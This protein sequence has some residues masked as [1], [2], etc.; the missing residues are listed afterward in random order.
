[1]ARGADPVDVGAEPIF[2]IFSWWRITCPYRRMRIGG[3]V[4]EGMYVPW[5]AL[6]IF[7]VEDG[8]GVFMVV[9]GGTAEQSEL[10]GGRWWC[11]RLTQ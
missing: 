3:S 1:M 8:M 7:V 9:V 11:C 5:V 2:K 6:A 4:V 10:F